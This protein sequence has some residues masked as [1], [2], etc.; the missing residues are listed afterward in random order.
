MD[1]TD[2]DFYNVG[3]DVS[4]ELIVFRRNLETGITEPEIFYGSAA[5]EHVPTFTDLFDV[6]IGGE[7]Y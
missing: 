2:P 1:I 7:H 4:G 5:L 3:V 6:S